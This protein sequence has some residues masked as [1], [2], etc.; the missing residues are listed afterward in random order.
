MTSYTK[1][2]A[3]LFLAYGKNKYVIGLALNKKFYI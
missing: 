2:V 3:M 1:L